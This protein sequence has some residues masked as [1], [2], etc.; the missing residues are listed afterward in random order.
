MKHIRLMHI[1]QRS[2]LI[3]AVTLQAS[4]VIAAQPIYSGGKER[5]AI[6]GYDSVAYF[7][8]NKPVK[9]S[10]DFSYEYQGATWLFASEQ[11]LEV[12]KQNPEQYMPQYGGYCAYAVSR[13][14]TAS[15]KP[16]YFQIY[17]GKLYLNY[18]KSVAKR[19]RKDKDKYIQEANKHWP[20]VLDR[21]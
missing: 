5:A 18:S 13:G 9:G 1:I 19:W 10:T 8:Q 16:E 4:H 21:R 12:F 14:T 6:R 7:T 11:N 3:L 2:L 20:Q 17:Q 15:I